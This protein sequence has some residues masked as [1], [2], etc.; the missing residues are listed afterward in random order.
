MSDFEQKWETAKNVLRKDA[1]DAFKNANTWAKTVAYAMMLLDN[2]SSPLE[3]SYIALKLCKD[4]NTL[5]EVLE[6]LK[7]NEAE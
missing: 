1:H 4:A 7:M 2:Q 6:W 5:E 3:Y